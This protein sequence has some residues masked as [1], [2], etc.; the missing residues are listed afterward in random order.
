LTEHVLRLADQVASAIGEQRNLSPSQTHILN[1]V[2][3]PALNHILS[4]E[5]PINRKPA[6][7]EE[8]RRK[9]RAWYLFE[10]GDYLEALN[11]GYPDGFWLKCVTHLSELFGI[12]PSFVSKPRFP[13]YQDSERLIV[14][15]VIFTKED[16]DLVVWLRDAICL[17]AEGGPTKLNDEV[18][19][20][21][22]RFGNTTAVLVLNSDFNSE[23]FPNLIA[24]SDPIRAAHRAFSLFTGST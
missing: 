17:E 14:W 8:A 9:I 2:Y 5:E 20:F 18:D 16:K 15:K 13:P 4:Y 1:G 6:P 10:A 7:E 3:L 12:P 21:K 19:T 23:Q 11:F 22:Q 24:N